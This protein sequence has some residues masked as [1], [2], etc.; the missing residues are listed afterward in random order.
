MKIAIEVIKAVLIVMT[1][2]TL[3]LGNDKV[4]DAIAER[5]PNKFSQ[6][7]QIDFFLFKLLYFF[8]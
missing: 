5:E 2:P 1:K 3:G 8:L 6:T 7:I 4:D